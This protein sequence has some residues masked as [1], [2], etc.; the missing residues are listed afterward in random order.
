M[1]EGL[2]IRPDP[3]IWWKIVAE[4]QVQDDVQL[5]DGDP[6]AEEAGPG[7]HEGARPVVAA[8]S[9]PGRRAARRADGAL[10]GG[11]AAAS[12]SS[13]TTGRPR[14]G[15]P[16]LSAQLGR[17]GD[18]AQ[19]RQPVV[20]GLRLRRAGCCDEATGEEVGADE[21]GVLAIVPP[22]PPGCMT[23]VWGDDE[24]FVKTYFSTFPAAASTRRSTGR[25]ATPTA[26]TS[27]SAAP[28]TSSTSPA[29]ASARARSR[30]RCRRIAGIAEV[31][32]VGVADRS[33]ARCRS[34]SPW[35]RIRRRIA[36]A[37]RH[38]ARCARKSWPPST[39][40]WA[41]SPGRAPC[42]SSRCC[43]RRAR[44]SSCGASI[45]ALAE[46]RDP[47]DLTTIEDPAALDQIRGAL[48]S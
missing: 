21:K 32:V 2:P 39:A 42:T 25:R 26:T 40:S 15:W 16:I 20:P 41:R 5:A 27:C 28:T 43:P 35:S 22:L 45:Q 33:R 47:G 11:R 7:V 29:T 8:L 10:G 37:G 4:N 44:A 19:V 1:Y 12:R 36:T 31:A 46:G 24:R 23:T 34:P 17:R 48:E 13:T 3:G 38:R 9:V 14:R 30:R 6:G 18:A